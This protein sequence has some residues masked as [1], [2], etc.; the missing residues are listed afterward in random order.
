MAANKEKCPSCGQFI[1][2][3]S[4]FCIRCGAQIKKITIDE[5]DTAPKE[6]S[7]ITK[8][9]PAESSGGKRLK[10]AS[11]IEMPTEPE[12]SEPE[13]PQVPISEPE[14]ETDEEDDAVSPSV[15]HNEEI[16]DNSSDEDDSDQMY[17]EE[18]DDVEEADDS[19]LSNDMESDTE[20]DLDDDEAFNALLN[21][22]KNAT[23]KPNVKEKKPV[24]S[25]KRTVLNNGLLR[26]PP[27]EVEKS[28]PLP[29]RKVQ[30]AEIEK[31]K[32]KP[33]YNPN[34]DHYYDNVMAEVDARISHFSKENVVLT[35]A[36]SI[37]C[38]VILV[39]MIYCIVL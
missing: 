1:K 23:A 11:Y 21:A 15:T 35:I 36:F 31:T 19:S 24:S 12:P 18:L 7:T 20:T 3:G 25:N 17:E 32:A 13:E 39:A 2:A 34:E 9:A 10:P 5:E 6:E 28:N 38:I 26:R 27:K 30:T 8:D 4:P 37:L 16:E 33:P 29:K 22:K 14:Y